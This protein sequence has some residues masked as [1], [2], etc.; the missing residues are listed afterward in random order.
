LP[1]GSSLYKKKREGEEATTG[2]FG[3]ERKDEYSLYAAGKEGASLR[4][5]EGKKEDGRKMPTSPLLSA[6]RLPLSLKR[7]KKEL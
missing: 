4:I 7:G 2:A 6:L 1:E 3:K 5:Q